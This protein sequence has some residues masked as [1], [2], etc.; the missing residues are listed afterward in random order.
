MRWCVGHTTLRERFAS[1]LQSQVSVGKNMD[2]I[3]QKWDIGAPCGRRHIAHGW[4]RVLIAFACLSLSLAPAVISADQP[5]NADKDDE[6]ATL[7]RWMTG[8]FDTFAQVEA[9]LAAG[10]AYTHLKAVMHIVPVTIAGLTSPGAVTLYVEQ[11]AA[12]A[13]HAPYRQRV[14]L[15]TRRDGALVNRTFR[16]VEPQRLAGAH[17]RPELLTQLAPEQLTLEAGCD[18]VWTRIGPELYSGVAGIGG[19]CST[20]WRGAAYTVS[21]VLMTPTTI[22]S[23]DQGFDAQ[24]RHV[25]GPPP[26][27]VGHVFRK[28]EAPDPPPPPA[29]T[30][31]PALP[32]G[33]HQP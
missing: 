19:S 28:R 30:P 7:A 32:P 5:G 25:W 14:Y 1:T 22:T 2:A 12:D 18:L 16:I 15:L 31:T 9:D 20:T 4:D 8:S 6:L 11:A 27:T 29:G 3:P 26:G 24:G 21:Q 10:A 23:L 13:Q 17:A 33:D